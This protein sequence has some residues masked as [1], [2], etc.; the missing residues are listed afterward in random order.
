MK[1]PNEQDDLATYARFRARQRQQRRERGSWRR[2]KYILD[3]VQGKLPPGTRAKNR[4]PYPQHLIDNCQKMR[5][6]SWH[7][8][9]DA[10][11]REAQ[12]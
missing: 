12:R 5:A 3:R 2:S 6:R 11:V 4:G 7:V 10:A 9:D 1:Q 8:R